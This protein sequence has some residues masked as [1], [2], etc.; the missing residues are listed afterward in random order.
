MMT[1]DELKFYYDV[2]DSILGLARIFD[3]TVKDTDTILHSNMTLW[4]D[5][6]RP[7]LERFRNLMEVTTKE[8][9]EVAAA[10]RIKTLEALEE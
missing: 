10:I 3:K 8:A 9:E 2:R 5:M 6:V 4:V 7:E 1:R